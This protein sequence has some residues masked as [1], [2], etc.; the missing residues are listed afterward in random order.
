M[1]ATVFPHKYGVTL[2]VTGEIVA[3]AEEYRAAWAEERRLATI[4]PRHR[5]DR[6]DWWYVCRGRH[7]LESL[8]GRPAGPL[9]RAPRDVTGDG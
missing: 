8:P 7:L 3:A 2:P 4:G 1:N 5:P 9:R 6:H